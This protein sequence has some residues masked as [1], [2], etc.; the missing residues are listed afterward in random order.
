MLVFVMSGW[1]FW[2]LF[3]VSVG[4]PSKRKYPCCD[5]VFMYN[6]QYSCCNFTLKV[7]P[8]VGLMLIFRSSRCYYSTLGPS[9]SSKVQTF[10]RS[11]EFWVS[12]NWARFK[13][14]L[15]SAVFLV[16]DIRQEA[17]IKCLLNL[18]MKGNTKTRRDQMLL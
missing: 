13:S 8:S 9:L 14:L 6:N 2:D 5:L 4:L 3:L 16:L 12:W 11:S 7:F 10:Q 18:T 1:W 17:F 15:F